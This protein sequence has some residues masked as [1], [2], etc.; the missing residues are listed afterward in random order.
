MMGSFALPSGYDWDTKIFVKQVKTKSWVK[1]YKK[2]L[3]PWGYKLTNAIR[4]DRQIIGGILQAAYGANIG[5]QVESKLSDDDLSKIRLNI[6]SVIYE[7]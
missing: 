6:I 4:D 2:Y 3:N 5:R 1:K 7:N